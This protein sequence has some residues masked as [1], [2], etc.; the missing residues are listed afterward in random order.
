MDGGA[1]HG[2]YHALGLS[3]AAELNPDD[4]KKAYRKMS[5]KYH[6]VRAC[7]VVCCRPRS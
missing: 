2:L 5:L 1:Q 6:P 7:A 4:V 3:F